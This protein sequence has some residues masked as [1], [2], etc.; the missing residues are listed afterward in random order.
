M[1]ADILGFMHFFVQVHGSVN[2]LYL[3]CLAEKAA[4]SALS[5]TELGEAR[6]TQPVI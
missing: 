3:S 1:L 5:F 2:D 6:C 4:F